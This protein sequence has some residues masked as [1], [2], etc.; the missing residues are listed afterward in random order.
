MMHSLNI[1][2][3]SKEFMLSLKE[4]AASRGLHLRDYCMELLTEGMAR[5]AAP[6]VDKQDVEAHRA[7]QQIINTTL[8]SVKFNVPPR[9]NISEET[10]KAPAIDTARPTETAP[11]PSEPVLCP[12][13]R[14]EKLKARDETTLRCPLCGYQQSRI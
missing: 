8:E 2:N 11:K 5:N 3:V 7:Q 14:R 4:Q 13:C 10:K 6:V 12:K 9:D 1:R